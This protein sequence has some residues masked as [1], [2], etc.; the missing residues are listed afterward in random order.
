MLR[1]VLALVA[2][3]SLALAA[4]KTCPTGTLTPTAQTA[5]GATTD[6][7]TARGATAIVFQAQNT[8]GTA[9]VE[10]QLCCL[11]SCDPATGAWSQ[12][13][14]SPMTLTVS[15]AAKGV[16][17]PTCIYRANAT[18]CASCSVTVGFSCAGP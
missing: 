6:T 18:A 3:A 15:S 17:N 4:N 16:A 9:T 13:E 1:T 10:V 12:V 2:T 8:A 5:T 7:V 11:G 14:N